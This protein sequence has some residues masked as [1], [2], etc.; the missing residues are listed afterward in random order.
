MVSHPCWFCGAFSWLFQGSLK[1]AANVL[2][3]SLECKIWTIRDSWKIRSVMN[4]IGFPCPALWVPTNHSRWGVKSKSH[5]QNPL[6]FVDHF[7]P[8]ATLEMTLLS[9]VCI[10]Q[11]SPSTY[12]T[13]DVLL[14]QNWEIFPLAFRIGHLLVVPVP[15]WPPPSPQCPYSGFGSKAPEGFVKCTDS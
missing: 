14:Q 15:F 7:H 2:A 9:Y 4:S 1:P 10:I 6:L 12:F 11:L 3:A 5:L 8:Y 13:H